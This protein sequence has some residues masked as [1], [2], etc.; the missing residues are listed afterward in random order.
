MPALQVRAE[1]SPFDTVTRTNDAAFF[2]RTTGVGLA[3]RRAGA[4]ILDLS[5]YRCQLLLPARGVAS[6]AAP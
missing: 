4:V 2:L 6:G 1:C 3:L 5:H